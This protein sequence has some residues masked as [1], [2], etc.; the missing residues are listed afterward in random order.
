MNSFFN[1][2][3]GN[4]AEAA[5]PNW[6][7]WLS[8]IINLIAIVSGY[9]IAR[10]IYN[11]EKTDRKTQERELINNE[12][13]VFKTSLSELKKSCDNQKTK[14]EEYLEKQDFILHFDQ[15]VNVDFLKFFDIK[16]LYQKIGFEDHSNL[17]KLNELLSSLYT[18][19]DFRNSLRDELRTY[20]E[21]YNFHEQKFYIYKKLLYNNYFKLCNKRSLEIINDNGNK[22]W[23]FDDQDNFMKVYSEIIHSTFDNVEII[24][25]GELKSRDKLTENFIKKL[26]SETS[27]FIPE[28][29]D[30]IKINDLSNQV[31][32]AFTDMT[33]ITESHFRAIKTYNESLASI[34]LKINSFLEIL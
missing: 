7:E 16:N 10:L 33:K 2:Q 34:S 21:K 27:K 20:I 11:R 23:K 13:E 8:F 12:T 6:F 22:K 25:N 3:F 29:Y 4:F 24:E 18:L 1:F 17:A 14:L 30:A 32:A 5:S 26:L 19:Y 28:D 15:G 9:I 31:Y